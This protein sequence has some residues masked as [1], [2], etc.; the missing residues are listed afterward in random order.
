MTSDGNI[1]TPHGRVLK[2]IDAY[3]AFHGLSKCIR[4][5]LYRIK[6]TSSINIVAGTSL[7]DSSSSRD[8]LSSMR[9]VP[10]HLSFECGWMKG[11]M[12]INDYFRTA[13]GLAHGVGRISLEG[14]KD[15]DKKGLI[16]LK[17]RAEKILSPETLHEARVSFY[18]GVEFNCHSHSMMEGNAYWAVIN[19]SNNDTLELKCKKPEQLNVTIDN[20]PRLAYRFRG[21]WILELFEASMDSSRIPGCAG[22]ET[23]PVFIQTHAIRRIEERLDCLTRL[24]MQTVPKQER[25]NPGIET[26]MRMTTRA[27]IRQSLCESLINPEIL[28]FEDSILLAH[29]LIGNRIGYLP[30]RI[31]GKI[32]VL[33]TFLFITMDGTPEGKKL[34]DALKL[35]RP[36]KKYL[37]LDSL[38]TFLLSDIKDDSEIVDTLCECGCGDLFKVSRLPV[39]SIYRSAELFHK[40]LP[41]R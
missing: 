8:I 36:D 27:Y 40:F 6:L 26:V 17:D 25:D 2:A 16:I 22:Q 34:H 10:D 5:E 30:F 11:D 13:R 38:E 4:S 37:K 35:R 28:E 7:D 14:K 24:L 41:I 12:S 33:T 1:N 18:K 19:K 9:I 39:K 29:R 31:I 15:G 32:I 20:E 23:Y 21:A 3:E